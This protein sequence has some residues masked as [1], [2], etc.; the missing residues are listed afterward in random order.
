ML[1]VE[2]I[3][4]FYGSSHI[5]HG[6]SLEVHPGE[7]VVLF[8]RNGVGKTTTLKSIMGIQPPKNGRIIYK[9]ED[10]T[11]NEPYLNVRKGL[12]L[13]PEDRRV[14][15]NLTVEENL[16]LGILHKK[17]Q[18]NVSEQ[19]DMVFDY[20]PKLKQRIKQLGGSLS[21]G[22]QQM[23]TIARGLISNPELMM[24]DEPTEGLAPLIVEEIAEILRRLQ[25]HG[26]TILLVEQNYELTISLSEN[27]R[28][29]VLEKGQV[30]LSGTPAELRACQEDVEACLGVK[31]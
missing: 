26:A 4:T 5:L 8:G 11:G 16:Q 27:L 18:L 20:F 3:N 31:L 21:G 22:E 6:V 24:I 9:G 25:R 1:K 14:I 28:A 17:K 23:L 29:Y 10:I 15:P 12:A 13:I 19:F 2:N 30:K 7:V